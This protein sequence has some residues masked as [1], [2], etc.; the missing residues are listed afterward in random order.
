MTDRSPGKASSG[1]FLEDFALGQVI[2]HATPRTV[3]RGDFAV[4]NSIY[5]DRHPLH[6]SD[7]FAR[8]CR[9]DAS[10]VHDLLVF[11]I[12]FGKTVR[13]LSLN[14]IANLGYAEA[15]FLKPVHYGDT[16]CARSRIIGI[17]ENSNGKT[18]IIWV[19]TTGLDQSDEPVLDYK[20]WV[21]IRK[22]DIGSPACEA[23][24]PT[25]QCAVSATDLPV[26]P[27]LDFRTFDTAATGE[28]YRLDDYAIGEVIDH[29]DCTTLTDTEHMLATRVYQNTARVHFDINARADR[30][31]LI[32]GGHLISLARAFTSN[33]LANAQPLLAINSGSHVNPAFAGDTVTARTEIIDHANHPTPGAGAIRLRTQL[34][35]VNDDASSPYG[36]ANLLLDLDCWCLMPD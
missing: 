10:P 3:T 29:I 13:D 32:Y 15:R 5:G 19:E 8:A 4:Y 34:G 25:T 6:C 14:A 18:G 16:L 21:M 9:L 31:R 30:K 11:H 2:T 26:P 20:R 24:V 36:D 28:A 27:G 1:S 7:S 12:V 17:K 22:R 33:G 23:S 35:K